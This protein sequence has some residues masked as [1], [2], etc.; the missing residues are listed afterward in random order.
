MRLHIIEQQAS[1]VFFFLAECKQPELRRVDFVLG[2]AYREQD[3][4]VV[5]AYS[6]FLLQTIRSDSSQQSEA[7][8]KAFCLL[9]VYVGLWLFKQMQRI[10]N[11]RME[12]A[13]YEM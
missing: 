11:E 2:L 9:N 3:T 13:K 7:I 10:E 5:Q 8:R 4:R 1:D 6:G 12:R